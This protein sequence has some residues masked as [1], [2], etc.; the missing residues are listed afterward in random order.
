MSTAAPRVLV[1][2][3]AWEPH[4]Q[5]FMPGSPAALSHAWPTRIAYALVAVLVG[6]TGGLGS[7]L[8]TANLP[9]IQGQL[10]LTP[11][12]GAWLPAAYVMVN[13]TA[14]LLVFKFRQQFGMRLFAELALGLYAA[15]ALLH[16]AV[17]GYTMAV[18]VRAASGFVGAATSTLAVLYMLQALPRVRV[19]S[20]FVIGLGLSQLATPLAW[21]LSP[22]LLDQADWRVLYAF[23]AGLALCAFA[24]VVSLKLPVG[25]RIHV[26]EKADFLTFALVAPGVA[27]LGAVLAQG[28]NSWWTDTAWLA[29][30]LIG[31]IVLLTLAAMH[32]YRRERPLLQ[33]RWLLNS[34]TLAFVFGAL[35]MRFMLAEQSYGAVGLLRM[36]GMGPDQ[37][38]PLF[39]VMLL[40][41]LSG[42]ALSAITFGPKAVPLQLLGS[43]VL[44]AIAG[45]MDHQ[46]T[47]LSR[48]QDFYASQFLLSFAAA[49]FLGPLMLSGVMQALQHGAD[50]LVSFIVLF[51]VT[52]AL[53]GLAGPALLGTL[54][55]QR[56]AVHAQAIAAHVQPTQAAVAQRLAQQQR[57]YGA[58]LADPVQRAAQG[59][60]QLGQTVR[61]QAA[62]RA[63]ND[64]FTL[65]GALAIAYLGWM[66][67]RAG[68][69]LRAAR[70]AA[71][72]PGAGSV[73]PSSAATPPPARAGT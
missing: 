26:F 4:E 37:L 38:Q 22:A 27:L 41:M 53:G 71:A 16:L 40:G 20:A 44:I 43:V 50:H 3:P 25:L 52:Q 2:P 72:S 54:Q 15:L 62:V 13:V 34:S 63:F 14:N 24:A 60:A 49:M 7:A 12:E 33:V 11:A 69:V 21:V 65:I 64:V 45:F 8:I 18:L 29:W 46:S 6:L 23:E 32:E 9:T 19:G 10:G 42:M 51:S 59:T 5:P 1:P 57:V 67:W 31:A 28:L 56:T 68:R 70:Q 66:L 35:M 36:L 48:P 61:R 30:A 47:S 73:T 17:D 39:G 58:V 55:A